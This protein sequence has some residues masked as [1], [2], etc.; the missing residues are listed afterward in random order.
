MKIYQNLWAGYETYFVRTGTT[1]MNRHDCAT[2]IEIVNVDG[3]WHISYGGKYYAADLRRDVEHF[4]V[5]GHI[6]LK[7][8]LIE[9]VLN[10]VKGEQ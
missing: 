9:L 10:A 8:T 5:V 2:G 6:D 3:D 1:T 4:P 7:K